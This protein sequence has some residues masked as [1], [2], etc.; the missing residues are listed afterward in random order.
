[1]ATKPQAGSN[2]SPDVVNRIRRE[3]LDEILDRGRHAALVTGHGHDL[4]AVAGA[5]A[6]G[7]ADPQAK[8]AGL[9][10]QRYAKVSA[11][12]HARALRLRAALGD[13]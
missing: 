4:L 8:L 12:V 9:L 11:D 7:P 3:V 10:M 1:M 5:W 13:G 6:A 2:L